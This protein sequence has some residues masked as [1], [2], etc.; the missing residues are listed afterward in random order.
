MFRFCEH[1]LVGM[2]VGFHGL[3]EMILVGLAWC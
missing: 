1:E 2:I 3:Y